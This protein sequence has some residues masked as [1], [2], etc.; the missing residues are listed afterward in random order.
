MKKKINVFD[1]ASEINKAFR[2]GILLNTRNEKFDA[3]VIGWGALGVNWG[4]PCFTVYVR[5]SRFTHAQLDANPN[6]TISVPLGDLDRK[7]LN[8][9]GSQ[10]AR[11]IDKV[12]EAGLHLEEAL[13]NGVEGIR[14]VPLTLECRTVYRQDQ[15]TDLYPKE[16]ADRWY[17]E[18]P[19]NFHTMYIGEIQEAYIIQ[20]EEQ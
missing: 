2:G 18:R 5:Q 19:M 7:I 12:K 20:D 16:I 14:E 4:K 9:C 11:D 15:V 17:P 10:S 3:M 6:F 8:I 13:T 1:Y